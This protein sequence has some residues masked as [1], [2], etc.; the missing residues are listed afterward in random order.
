MRLPGTRYQEHGWE[1]VRKLLGQCSLQACAP[2][3][4]E[5][6][7][8]GDATSAEACLEDYLERTAALLHAGARHGRAPGDGNSY[9]DSVVELALGLLYELRARPAD[10]QALAAALAQ[11]AARLGA[12][13]RQAGGEAILRKKFNDMYAVLRDRV[14]ADNYMAACGRA[15]SANRMYAY[16]MLDT[17]YADIARLFEQWRQFPLQV[18]A[19]LGRPLDGASAPIE[20]RQMKSIGQCRG[21]WVIAWSASRETFTGAAGPLDTRSKRFASL[22]NNPDKIGLMLRE[23]GDYEELSANRDSDWAQDVQDAGAWLDDLAA[24]LESPLPDDGDERILAPPPAELDLPR[25]E[26]VPAGQATLAE[27]GAASAVPLVFASRHGDVARSMELLN[28]LTRDLPMSPTGFGLSVHNAIAALYSIAR[29]YRGN[30]LALAGGRATVEAACIE[31]AAL[32]ADGAQEVRLVVYE[33]PLPEVYADFADEPD[34]FFAWCWRLTA[35]H[36][37]RPT[38]RLDWSI[39]PA[40]GV[41]EAGRLPHALDLHRFL[42]AGQAALERRADGQC[43]RWTRHG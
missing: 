39:D 28:A 15:C 6:L 22:K 27:Q 8:S 41:P 42:L 5:R 18:G 38:L 2:D 10:W 1:Q 3:L 29:G 37:E 9:G 14:D 23:I 30:Y 13:W 21:A 32:L 11:D 19:I 12:D 20:V 35:P 31:A 24:V 25:D 33:S 16:R 34:P 26:Q 7:A 40:A 43:W 17:A 4:L 36:P